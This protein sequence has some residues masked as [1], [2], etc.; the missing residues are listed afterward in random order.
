MKDHHIKAMMRGIEAIVENHLRLF[1][2]PR[3]FLHIKITGAS[4][5]DDQKPM[6]DVGV[7]LL[8]ELPKGEVVSVEHRI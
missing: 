1:G 5:G 2:E 8:R 4:I 7:E 6:I 3:T